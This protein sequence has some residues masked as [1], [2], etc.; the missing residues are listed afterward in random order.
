MAAVVFAALALIA[1]F[2]LVA[3]SG[4]SVSNDDRVSAKAVIKGASTV[5]AAAEDT[6]LTQDDSPATISQNDPQFA[7]FFEELQQ[8]EGVRDLVL[9][10]CDFTIAIQGVTAATAREDSAQTNYRYSITKA[11]VTIDGKTIAYDDK[12]KSFSAN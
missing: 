2:G 6:G 9:E 1:M 4:N 3:C 10:N 12:T 5:L 7:W 8:T 11:H